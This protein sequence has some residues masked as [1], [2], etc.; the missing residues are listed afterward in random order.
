MQVSFHSDKPRTYE[1]LGAMKG[2]L[3][4]GCEDNLLRESESSLGFSDNRAGKSL[5]AYLHI[6]ESWDCDWPG[7]S[8]EGEDP[9]GPVQRGDCVMWP[10]IGARMQEN[11]QRH[12]T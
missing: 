5:T 10:P 7:S 8:T 1:F 11:K 2:L 9:A 12:L 3:R 4:A 6:Q